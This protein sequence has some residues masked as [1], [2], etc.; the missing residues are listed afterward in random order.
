MLLSG[1]RWMYNLLCLPLDN[2]RREACLRN[3]FTFW[4]VRGLFMSSWMSAQERKVWVGGR[5]LF[6]LLDGSVGIGAYYCTLPGNT[7]E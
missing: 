4:L 7:V 1:S 5:Q 6:C 3:I 2:E